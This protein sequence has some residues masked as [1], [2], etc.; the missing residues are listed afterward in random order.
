MT[1]PS[2]TL[3]RDEADAFGREFDALRAEVLAD[4]GQRDADHIRAVIKTAH[5]A[6]AAGRLLLHVGIGPVSFIAGAAALGLA[7]I[8]DNMEIG[9]NVMHGQYDWTGDP[10]LAGATYEWDTSCTADDW[11]HSHNYEHHT[12]TNIVGKDRDVGYGFLRVS[13]AQ[14]WHPSHLAQPLTAA[15]LAINFQWGV[16]THDLRIDETL[17]GRQS[18]AALWARAQP[19]LR[20]AGWQLAKDY[21]IYPA[22]ALGNAPRVAA[23]NLLA[24][25][26]RNLWTFAVIFCGHFPEGVRVYSEAETASESRGQ[27][28]LR[29]LNGSANIEGSRAMHVLTGHLSHQIEHH[30]FPDLPAARYPELAPRVRAICARYGQQYVTGSFAKQLGSVARRIVTLAL[31]SKRRAAAAVAAPVTAARRAA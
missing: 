24:N 9:H 1:T 8:L 6:E 4:L 23:G 30:L 12:F 15:L 17:A 26:T 19:F 11:R 5:T 21:A 20:K 14:A 3:T 25:L 10:A 31:P 27:W 28:Y 22:L 29:Q 16:A 7:K 13:E 18:A 2:R